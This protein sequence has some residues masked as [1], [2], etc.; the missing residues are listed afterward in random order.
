MMVFSAAYA[1]EPAEGGQALDQAANDPTAS[2]MNVQLQDVYTG[3]Y[4]NLKGESGNAILLRSAVPSKI[5]NIDNIARATLPIITESPSGESGLI[6]LVLFDLIVFDQPWG[7]W[8]VGPVMLMPTATKS[9]S[10]RCSSPVLTSKTSLTTM[11]HRNGRSIL[12]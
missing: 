11:W 8:G 9:A 7:C 10:C 12:Q 3:D 6:D 1:E 4:H 5:G 2:L